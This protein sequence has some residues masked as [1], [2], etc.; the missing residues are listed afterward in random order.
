MSV[1]PIYWCKQIIKIEKIVWLNLMV[2]QCQQDQ[3]PRG[4]VYS[5]CTF[6]HIFKRVYSEWNEQ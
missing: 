3:Y 1:A 6:F 2:L 5:F 4:D